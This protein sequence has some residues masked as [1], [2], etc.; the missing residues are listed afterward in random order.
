[1]IY[2]T[3]NDIDRLI[4]DDVP[5]GDI[6]TYLLGLSDKKG[7]IE[8]FARSAMTVCG[9]E[10]VVRMY[11]KVGLEIVSSLPSGTMLNEGDKLLEAR[12]DAASIHTIWRSGGVLIEFASGIATR[13]RQLVKNAKAANP[14]VVVA[15]TR[16]HPPY[17]KKVA[18]KALMAGGGIPHRTGISDTILMFREHL[19]FTGGYKNLVSL[20][21]K[22]KQQQKERKIVVEAHTYEEALLVAQAGADAIQ[23]DKMPPEIFKE[24]ATAGRNICPEICMIAAG[25]INARNAADYARASAD[26]LV[27]SWIYFAPPADIGVKILQA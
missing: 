21:S 4:E 2:F 14:D 25:G 24:T 13:T 27:T 20:I 23:I 5:L 3:E 18:L 6:T 16:K 7:K 9:V 15:G 1:M 26:V 22:V 12:G 8:L 17:L 11:K 10:E 19:L